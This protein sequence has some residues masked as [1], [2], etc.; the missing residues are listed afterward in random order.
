M[1]QDGDSK[2]NSVITIDTEDSQWQADPKYNADKQPTWTHPTEDDGWVLAH[3]SLRSELN[4]IIE[5]VESVA[6]KFG[7]AV[8]GWAIHCI[9]K[10]WS[11]HDTHVHSHHENEDDIMTPFMK[12]RINLPQKLES[13]HEIVCDKINQVTEAVQGLAEGSSIVGV[14]F[15]LKEYKEVLFPHLEEEEHIAL[16]LLRS[17]FDPNEVGKQVQKIV[18]KSPKCELGSFIYYQTE[19]NFRNKFMK[20]EGI[21]FFVW[22]LA[23]KSAYKHFLDNTV[24]NLEALKTGVPPTSVTSKCV[25]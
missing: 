7:D 9:Q 11:E 14:V 4:D 1:S 15:A 3:N 2:S 13:D 18:G 20:Q 24:S 23:F 5:A 21:P 17:Y 16:P 6:T 12:T 25:C 22:Y 10:V 19:D 8:P